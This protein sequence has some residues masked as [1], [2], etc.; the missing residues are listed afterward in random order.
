MQSTDPHASNGKAHSS[1]KPDELTPDRDMLVRFV[2]VMFKNANKIGF[3]SFR[4]FRDNGKSERPVLIQALR[5][6]DY[7]FEP[8]MLIPAK[9]AANW[10]EPAVFCPPVATFKDHRNAKA[11]NVLEGVALS[12]DCDQAPRHGRTTLEAV[13]GQSTIVSESGGEWMDPETGEIEPKAHLHWRL[14][15][16][17]ATAEAQAML[18]EARWLAAK[19]IGSDATAI[20][21]VHPLRWPGSWHC[22]KKPPRLARIAAIS[23]ATEI[24]LAE[25]LAR[26]REAAEAAG[27]VQPGQANGAASGVGGGP[28]GQ[29]EA[30][31]HSLVD[32]TLSVIPNDGDRRDEKGVLVCDWTYW[33]HVGMTIWAS[34]SGSEDGRRAFHTWS[35]K[36]KKYDKAETNARWDHYFRSPPNRLGFGSLVYRARQAD[37]NWHYGHAVDA[38]FGEALRSFFDQLLR[39]HDDPDDDDGTGNAGPS[40]GNG[41]SPNAS[42]GAGP[43]PGAGAGAGSGGAGSGG[44]G[45]PS[46]PGTGP[47]PGASGPGAAG[48]GSNSM[49]KLPFHAEVAEELLF[50]MSMRDEE[51][52]VVPDERGR[53]HTWVYSN[54]LWSLLAEP[55]DWL[56]HQIEMT[57]REMG[58]SSASKAKFITEARKSSA[59]RPSGQ[60][61]WHGTITARCRRAR[62]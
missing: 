34:T 24:D 28:G 58:C 57:L 60:R 13:L 50:R 18:Y 44:P 7:E 36:H 29:R 23:E 56:D 41:A 6:D 38:G 10:Y 61:R 37:P 17:A 52:R 8:L 46:G 1:G 30:S 51:I 12:V 19:L 11:D 2:D 20:S 33:N 47:G 53:R 26:L 32:S 43:G 9:Q 45:G 5:L 15:Q 27:I 48:T 54:G 42:N 16:P 35:A 25:A 62:G 49:N 21:I 22:K 3:V 59:V 4:V 40:A 31:S 55:G 14:K 39:D